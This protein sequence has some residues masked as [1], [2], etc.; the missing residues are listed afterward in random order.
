MSVR[1]TMPVLA[2]LAVFGAGCADTG[3]LSLSADDQLAAPGQTVRVVTRIARR[4][5][6]R[7]F[8]PASPPPLRIYRNN[9]LLAEHHPAIGSWEFVTD[10]TLDTV[11]EHAIDAI[12]QPKVKSRPLHA[13]CYAYCW[14]ASRVAVAVDFD[15]VVNHSTRT[16]RFFAETPFGEVR[17]EAGAVL[18]ALAGEFFICYLTEHPAELKDDIRAWLRKNELPPGPIIT[19]HR[20][21]R[22]RLDPGDQ[23]EVLRQLQSQ[24]PTLLVGIGDGQ[25]DLAAFAANRMF[26]VLIEFGRSVRAAPDVPRC[27][28]WR[29]AWALFSLPA[30]RPILTDPKQMLELHHRGGDYVKL[31][32]AQ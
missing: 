32:G 7:W 1:R 28:T 19:W 3:G 20:G 12:Y 17:D 31:G 26:A 2:A 23:A 15:R 8:P 14:D 9:E 22:M 5:W 10:V 27:R 13:T 24:V 29:E 18:S 4:G 6:N 30:N 25:D 11:G 21:R 16:R